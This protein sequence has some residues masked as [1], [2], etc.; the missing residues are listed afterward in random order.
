MQGE[1]MKSL[2]SKREMMKIDKKEVEKLK[3][4]V[5]SYEEMLKK[6]TPSKRK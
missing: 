6:N 3:G 4:K 1:K 2:S 5:K